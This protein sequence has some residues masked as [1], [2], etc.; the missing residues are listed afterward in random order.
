MWLLGVPLAVPLAVLAFLSGYIPYFGG[1]VTTAIILV[2]TF[3]ALGLQPVIVLLV[4][5]GVRNA[6]LGYLVRPA[7]YGRTVRIH[8]ALVLLVLPAGFELAG[9][10]GLFAAVPITAIVLAVRSAVVEIIDPVPRPRLPVLVPA[11]LDRMA[12]WSW[13]ILVSLALVALIVVVATTI[14]LVVIPLVIAVILAATLEPLVRA[15][16]PA[17]PLAGKSR[18]DRRR[19]RLPARHGR[20][21]PDRLGAGGSGGRGR[22]RRP[23]P[24]P[25]RSAPGWADTWTSAPEP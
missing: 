23:P 9:V 11:W 12:Q 15:L 13:R 24:E 25:T 10:V 6:V 18:R 16:H 20:A 3:A 1:I 5:I 17:R 21:R 7:V 14:P 4:L 19:R 2:V 22:E 8:P